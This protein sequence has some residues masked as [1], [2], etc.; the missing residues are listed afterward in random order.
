MNR[1]ICDLDFNKLLGF[2]LITTR[3]GN[4]IHLAGEFSKVGRKTSLENINVRI[5]SK[6]GGKVGSKTISYAK[7]G[8]KAGVKI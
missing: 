8:S 5:G 7:I 2:R 4:N 1:N 3:E 6:A